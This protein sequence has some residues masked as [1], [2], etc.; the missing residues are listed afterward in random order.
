[1]SENK[2][3]SGNREGGGANK[4][5]KGHWGGPVSTLVSSKL[6]WRYIY[7]E[8]YIRKTVC[9]VVKLCLVQQYTSVLLSA[10]LA[11]ATAAAAPAAGVA[12]YKPSGKAIEVGAVGI[13]ATCDQGK[14]KKATDELTNML[15]EVR[16]CYDAGCCGWPC[17]CVQCMLVCSDGCLLVT[18]LC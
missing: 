12:Q 14:D 9:F 11:A 7:G 17:F 15:E 8:T 13:Y 10:D 6:L 1:M 3:R 16:V 18:T 2:K 5:P 4:K